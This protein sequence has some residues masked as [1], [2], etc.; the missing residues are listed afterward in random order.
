MTL[1]SPVVLQP[2][3]RTAPLGIR[4]WDDAAASDRVDDLQVQA[5]PVKPS[6]A[7]PATAIRSPGGCYV[8]SGLRGLHDFE[9]SAGAPADFSGAQSRSY[10]VEVTD[11]RGR[12]LPFEFEAAPT[13]GLYRLPCTPLASPH[14]DVGRHVPLFS[15]PQRPVPQTVAVVRAQLMTAGPA[16]P[17]PVRCALLAVSSGG[18][19]LGLGLSDEQGCVAVMFAHPAPN[20]A[21]RVPASPPP[22]PPPPPVER[23]AWDIDLKVYYDKSGNTA[24]SRPRLC[25]VLA[26][27]TLPPLRLLSGLSPPA[28]LG[29]QRLEYRQPLILR[30]P[31][32]P[33]ELSSFVFVD[34]A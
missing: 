24:R 3:W 10:R 5:S 1:P 29:P 19:E 14:R 16:P 25:D 34:I 2:S 21:H 4:F 23:F 27:L 12:F 26:Q 17:A 22:S 15:A 28:E 6:F 9:F 8:L 7:A 32:L 18:V 30:S 33:A 31:G 13:A 20:P 11:P